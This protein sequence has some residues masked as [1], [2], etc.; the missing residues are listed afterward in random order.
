MKRLG[1]FGIGL[2]VLSV[3]GLPAVAGE[4][5]SSDLALLRKAQSRLSAQLASA[6]AQKGGGQYSLLAERRQVDDM[7][8]A[9]EAGKAVDPERIERALKRSRVVQ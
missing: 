1:A 7:I 5:R 8:S 2:L 6:S 4:T 3:S 9:L